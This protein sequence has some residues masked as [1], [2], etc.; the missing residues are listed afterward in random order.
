MS[1]PEPA[2]ID[3]PPL[4][5]SREAVSY[6]DLLALIKRHE[7][8]A[9]LCDQLEACADALPAWPTQAAVDTL[10]RALADITRREAEN[11]GS[12]AAGLFG[13]VAGDPLAAALFCHVTACN[14]ADLI[15]AQD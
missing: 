3:V 14:T 9:R 12:L 5:A 2:S 7:Q 1:E 11:G 4:A 15:H 6:G 10:C 13:Q 8:L